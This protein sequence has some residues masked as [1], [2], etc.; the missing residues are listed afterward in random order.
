MNDDDFL[1][2]FRIDPA[3]LAAPHVPAKIRKRREQFVQVP[4]W[5]IEKLGESPLATGATH[6]V[7]CYLCH[8][9]WKHR[10]KPFNLPNGMLKYDG[11][12]RQSKWRALADLERRKLIIVERRRR[13]SPIIR[14]ML[15]PKSVSSVRQDVS[16]P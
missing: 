7:A 10:G 5:W 16:H 2:K 13:K 15:P 4:M 12:S 9:D 6:Q 11:I 1:A 3:V 8:L 14:M